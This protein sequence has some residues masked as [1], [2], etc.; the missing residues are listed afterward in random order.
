MTTVCLGWGSLIWDQCRAAEL[1]TRGCWHK[2]GPF[3]PIEFARVSSNGRLTLVIMPDAK[4]VP[5][6]WAK[7][8]VD[9]LDEAIAQVLVFVVVLD[10]IYRAPAKLAT[11]RWQAANS[12]STAFLRA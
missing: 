3:L 11:R 9:S 5:V 7:L 10:L 1:P 6:Q 8:D 12:S 4:L 2:D